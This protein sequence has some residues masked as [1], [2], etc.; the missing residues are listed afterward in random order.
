MSLEKEIENA[1]MQIATDSY[2]MSVGEVINLY[3]DG[4]IIIN[5]NF[6]RLFRW[7]DFQKSHLIES[8]LLGIPVPPIF[9]FETQEGPWELIDGL[10]RLS[11]ILEFI[12]IL[13]DAD[14]N[15]MPPSTLT[16]TKYLPSLEGYKWEKGSNKSSFF[17]K[18]QQLALKRAKI[19]VQIL[20]K[21][22]DEK[23]K[24]DLFRRL[25]S[26]GSV[27]KPQEL[28][29]CLMIMLN[30]DLFKFMDRL[31]KFP[32]FIRVMNQTD[33]SI[34]EQGLMD[35]VTRFIVFSYVEYDRRLDIEEYLDEGIIDV[36]E[37]FIY[38]SDKIEENF[39][40]T[41]ELLASISEDSLKKFDGGFKGR[42]GQAAFEVIA[43]GVAHNLHAIR[44]KKDPRTFVLDK[45][46]SFWMT[47]ESLSFT[48]AGLRGTQRIQKS[49][50]FGQK[51]FKP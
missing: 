14:G 18:T 1:S 12:G 28:R 3:R 34:N 46:K 24:F 2:D 7:T 6:Q 36:A 48:A 9:V 16:E 51:W 21:K 29:N 33:R 39:F 8:L 50:P 41:F 13:R 30:E 25:N 15:L 45:I 4:E 31:A 20:R 47:S 32:P 49:I 38:G 37:D 10:Q 27:A 23:A 43:L 11:T 35:Y 22:S 44:K 5:P 17:E 40:G 19:G 42:V 26:H